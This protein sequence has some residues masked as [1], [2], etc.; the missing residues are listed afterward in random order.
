MLKNV[1]LTLQPCL[2]PTCDLKKG[3]TRLFSF[4]QEFTEEYILNI[5]L[6]NFLLQ[7]FKINLKK[8][9]SLLS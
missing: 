3:V 1:G 4:I 8:S 2:T 5:T 7:P 9:P 6:M